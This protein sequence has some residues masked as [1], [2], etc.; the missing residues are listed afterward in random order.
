MT[1]KNV[2]QALDEGLAQTGKPEFDGAFSP[3][4]DDP[5]AMPAGHEQLAEDADSTAHWRFR[6]MAYLTT[7]VGIILLPIALLVRT[8]RWSARILMAHD[9]GWEFGGW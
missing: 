5:D 9:R 1:E 7:L 4:A 3:P 6:R 2:M 8:G